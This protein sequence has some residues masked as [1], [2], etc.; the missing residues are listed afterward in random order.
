[1]K[2]IYILIFTS[3]IMIIAYSDVVDSCSKIDKVIS[4]ML[5]LDSKIR[6]EIDTSSKSII[7]LVKD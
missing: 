3:I 4:E 6:T 1:M 7:K 2:K 5:D